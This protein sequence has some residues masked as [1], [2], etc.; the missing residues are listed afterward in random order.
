VGVAGG[1][2]AQ[3]ALRPGLPAGRPVAVA[4]A[5]VALVLLAA[6]DLHGAAIVAG[7]VIAAV[8]GRKGPALAH[9]ARPGAERWPPCQGWSG[10]M[11]QYQMGPL[12]ERALSIASQQ[13]TTRPAVHARSGG[14]SDGPRHSSWR[15]RSSQE[16]RFVSCRVVACGADGRLR[17]SAQV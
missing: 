13:R 12:S 7:I 14:A 5:I 16:E 17:C 3:V 9:D 10:A 6:M 8:T 4:A 1:V 2:V 15:G 11:G